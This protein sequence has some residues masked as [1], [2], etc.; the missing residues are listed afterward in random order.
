LIVY[1]GSSSILN[2][3]DDNGRSV[4]DDVAE[5]SSQLAVC[6]VIG[7]NQS[8]A[9]GIEI[10]SLK[11]G[12]SCVGTESSEMDPDVLRDSKVAQLQSPEPAVSSSSTASLV[13][14]DKLIPGWLPSDPSD[15]EHLI[16]ADNLSDTAE[17]FKR[18]I[19]IAVR[20]GS[21]VTI[22][23][24]MEARE[25]LTERHLKPEPGKFTTW[26]LDSTRKREMYPSKWGMT[27]KRVVSDGPPTL[28]L[29]HKRAPLPYGGCYLVIWSGDSRSATF[30][31]SDVASLLDSQEVADVCAWAGGNFTSL[32]AG[33]TLFTDGS[34]AGVK[35]GVKPN[36][37]NSANRKEA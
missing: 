18:H 3:R 31:N 30:A 27:A 16:N 4:P 22:T 19:T 13:P 20:S 26:V 35:S 25:H 37:K 7:W 33:M 23:N 5:L 9:S 21:D 34:V 32:R 1:G 10:W 17:W 14:L 24:P 29:L 6:D 28:D 2:V 36:P 11:A 12:Y 8:D 15:G